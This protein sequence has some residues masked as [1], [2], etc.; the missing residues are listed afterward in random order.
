LYRLHPC[1]AK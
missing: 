1:F